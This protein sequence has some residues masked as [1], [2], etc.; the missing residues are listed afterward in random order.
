MV[1]VFIKVSLHLC[2][3]V[4]LVIHDSGW[5][6]LEHLLLS[7]SPIQSLSDCAASQKFLFNSTRTE[8]HQ[9]EKPVDH[10]ISHGQMQARCSPKKR[11]TGE[12]GRPL[13]VSRPNAGTLLT[14]ETFDFRHNFWLAVLCTCE[15]NTNT[16]ASPPVP[17]NDPPFGVA[18]GCYRGTSRIRKRQPP[19]NS[20]GPYA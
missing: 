18:T 7:W 5:V 6:S 15:F 9:P 19:R 17:L 11:S 10:C 4:C 8:I 2:I 14:K 1:T 3:L 12:T 20:I 16:N 13:H